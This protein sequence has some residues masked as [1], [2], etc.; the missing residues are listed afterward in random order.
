MLRLRRR[1]G[2]EHRLEAIIAA[3][4]GKGE[5]ARNLKEK[6]ERQGRLTEEDRKRIAKW[7]GQAE[8]ARKKAWNQWVEGQLHKGGGKLFRWAQRKEAGEQLA[9]LE[10]PQGDEDKS[11]AHRLEKAKEVW[12]GLWT[13][14]NAWKVQRTRDLEPIQGEH[15]RRV[16]KR[17]KS[18]K[19]K[20]PDGWTPKGATS[21]PG[22]MDRPTRHLL[23]RV[24]RERSLAE[25]HQECGGGSHR[26]TRGQERRAAQAHWNTVIPVPIWMAIRK[27]QARDWS[28][29]IHGGAHEGAAA[30]ASRSRAQ[31]EIT[32]W[33][34][35]HTITAF[36]DCSKCYERIEHETAG[37]RAT[38]SGCPASIINMAMS[39]YSGPRYIRVHGAVAK[40]ARGRHG[41]IAGCSFAKDILKAFLVPI[42]ALARGTTFRDYVDDMVITSTGKQ[43]DQAVNKLIKDLRQ[44][45]KALR[46]D[47]MQLNE[48]KEQIFGPTACIRKAWKSATGREADNQVKDLGVFHYGH[49]YRHPVMDQKL[50][51][52][53]LTAE[54]IGAIPTDKNKKASM[55]AAV[56]YGKCF[57]GQEVHYI[58]QKHYEKLRT[59]M[60]AAMGENYT[61]R[62]R[63]PLLLHTAEGRFEPSV[64]RVGRLVRHW[65]KQGESYNVP[66]GYWQRCLQSEART[67]P[68]HLVA[69]MVQHL[70]INAI[71]PTIWEVDGTTHDLSAQHGVAEAVQRL[72]VDSLWVRLGTQRR[73]YQGL[74]RGRNHQATLAW[75]AQIQEERTKAF[76]DFIL[77]DAVYTPHRAH[78]RWGKP[79]HCPICRHPQGDWRHYVDDCPGITRREKCPGHFPD[80]LRYT[81]TVPLSWAQTPDSTQMRERETWA[82]GPS[83]NGAALVATDG[84]CRRTR[85][86]PRA[87]WGYASNHQAIGIRHGAAKG[88]HQTAQRGEVLGV[89]HAVASGQGRLHIL[90]DSKY[91]TVNLTKVIKGEKPKGKH[92]DLWDGIWRLKERIEAV[93]WVKAHLKWEEAEGRGIPKEHWDLNRLADIEAGKGVE[94]HTEDPGHWALWAFQLDQVRRQQQGLVRTYTQI[95]ELGIQGPSPQGLT[96]RSKGNGPTRLPRG[97]RTEAKWEGKHMLQGHNSTIGCLS[98]G[99]T[100][101]AKRQGRLQQ[102]RRPCVPLASHRQR[103]ERRHLLRWEGEWRCNR[104]PLKGKELRKHGCIFRHPTGGRRFRSKQGGVHPQ[105]GPIKRGSDA[106]ATGRNSCKQAKLSDCWAKS[107]RPRGQTSLLDFFAGSGGVERVQFGGKRPPAHLVGAVKRPKC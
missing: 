15:V 103:L 14:G 95:R 46:E 51:E 61:R 79:G 25:E 9:G 102:W 52:L 7:T 10:F 23:Q 90:T 92:A 81:G 101:R 40:P 91:V 49:G 107:A 26:E 71:G 8:K 1:E 38:S 83:R 59:L 47:N 33:E 78:L 37:K 87:G 100:T 55:A 29:A 18:G 28:L 11:I 2:Q 19:A 67:G 66:L 73:N 13:G 84:G 41:L 24:G 93:T 63:L 27:E 4:K 89:L 82:Q 58:T 60:V 105:G 34:G 42:S 77:T 96:T 99:R 94:M 65:V 75:R 20:G 12:S 69:R 48:A 64:C 44:I 6:V 72:V 21:A 56:L 62:P 16:L 30:M 5:E 54:R 53:K 50:R 35:K 36:L 88:P 70:G 3:G 45:K 39:I 76:L 97:L 43:A 57:Y 22:Q 80:C 17:L 74:Q 31:A 86:G 104:C 68:I 106:H 32:H 85:V 98:C